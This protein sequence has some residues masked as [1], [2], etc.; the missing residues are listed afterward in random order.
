MWTD[1]ST[2]VPDVCQTVQTTDALLNTNQFDCLHDVSFM[3]FYFIFNNGPN[4]TI[5]F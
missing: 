2:A 4:A 3:Y 5:E 1:G